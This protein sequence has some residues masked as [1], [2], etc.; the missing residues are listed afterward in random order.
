MTFASWAFST[1][2]LDLRSR[3]SQ[4]ALQRDVGVYF[5]K[6]GEWVLDLINVTKQ[7]KVMAFK[8]KLN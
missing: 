8:I 1:N 4:V 3:R 5:V 7:V 2:L 6:S